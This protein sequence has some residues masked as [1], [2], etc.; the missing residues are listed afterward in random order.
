LISGGEGESTGERNEWRRFGSEKIKV[1]P[2]L[3]FDLLAHPDINFSLAREK[4][5]EM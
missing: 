4:A 1:P 3:V 5:M 2:S